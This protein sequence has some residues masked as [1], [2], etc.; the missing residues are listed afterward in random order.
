[1]IFLARALKG[2]STFAL[3]SIY[4][5]K[6]EAKGKGEEKLVKNA[7]SYNIKYKF[8]VRGEREGVE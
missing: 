4:G 8:P 7:T 3:L 6:Q 2:E 5:R 1:M